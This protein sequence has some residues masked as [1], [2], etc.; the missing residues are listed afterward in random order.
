MTQYVL[1]GQL[2]HSLGKQSRLIT[3]LRNILEVLEENTEQCF[4]N[5][6]MEVFL[7][8]N[9]NPEVTKEKIRFVL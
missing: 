3:E 6:E 1:L 8:K 2:T 5:L 4:D 7:S 9:Q